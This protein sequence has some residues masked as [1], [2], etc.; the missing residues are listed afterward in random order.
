M[1]IFYE[2]TRIIETIK[3]NKS[4]R[5]KKL[6]RKNWL[7]SII[8]GDSL[9]VIPSIPDDFVDLVICSPPYNSGHRYDIYNDQKY[10]SEYI[11]SLEKIFKEIFPKLKNGGRVCINIGDGRNGRIATHCHIEEFMT[12]KLGYLPLAK[13]IWDKGHVSNRFSWGTFKSPKAP[14]LPI[15]YEYILVY[16]KKSLSLEGN[17]KSDLSKEEFINWSLA[18]WHFPREAYKESTNILKRNIHPAPFPEALAIRL[19][20]LFSWV[21]ATVLDP[22]SGSGTTLVACK[23]LG[24]N[25]IGIEISKDYCNLSKDRLQ[26]IHN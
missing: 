6:N 20:K 22:F 1:V 23:K 19:I 4:T 26:N 13:I 24:R 7:N 21:G 11:H 12:R 25:Y 2:K 9:S 5:K 15:P 18:L 16:A 3:E 14:S 17:G 8:N 10:H